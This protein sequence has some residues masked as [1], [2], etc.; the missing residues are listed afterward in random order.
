[1]YV[2]TKIIFVFLLFSLFSC[3]P[4][5]HNLDVS[6][7]DL[8]PK[9]DLLYYKDKPFSGILSSR[10][11][12]LAIN[13]VS[14]LEGRKHGEEQK[15][16]A[17]GKLAAIR[18]YQNGKKSGIHKAWWSNGQLKFIKKFDS[19]GN[20]VGIQQEWYSNGKLAKEFNYIDGKES[21]SQKI[22][23][24]QG[25][26]VANYQVINGERFGLIGSVNC[27]SDNYVD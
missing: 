3:N 24:Y 22:W 27:K 11:D 16:F 21:G 19:D 9:G 1:M 20:P 5:T 23:D 8:K 7:K 17:N 18:F 13:K 4:K 12:T 2:T 26:I 25:K 14:Y 15:L 6:N 10:V